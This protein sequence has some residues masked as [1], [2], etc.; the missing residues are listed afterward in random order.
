ML[1]RLLLV[2]VVSIFSSSVLIAKQVQE[3]RESTI[4]Y[5]LKV[6]ATAAQLKKFNNLVNKN[7]VLTKK[8]LKGSKTNVV[9]FK[10]I[11][12]LEK[13]FSKQ[14][15]DTG[16]VKFAEPDVSIPPHTVPNDPHYGVQWHH[17]TINSPLAWDNTQGSD[18]VKICVLDTGVDTDHPDLVG[19]LILP[20]YNAYLKVDGNV[21]DIYGHGTGTAG[22]VGAV[23][24]NA[25][26]VSGVNWNV[27][28][29]PVQINQGEISSSAYISDMAVGIEWCA[30]Q[31]AKVAN[32]SY[33]GAQYST[34]SESAQ[35]LRDSGGLLFMSAGNDG[36]NNS[37][38]TYPDYSSF[39]VVG[40]TGS[41]DIKSDFS[42]YGPFV[43]VVAP[44]ESIATTYLDGGYVY[45]SGTSFSSPM[46]AGLAG[47]IYSINPDFTPA[48]VEN[49][50]FDSSVDL[51]ELGDD[52]LYGKG[53]IDAGKAVVLAVNHLSP[54]N[55][56]VAIATS[57]KTVGEAPLNIVFDG[58]E[59][60]DSD[61]AITNYIWTFGDG[62]QASGVTT[63]HT[64]QNEGSFP[65]TLTVTDD[66]Y[67]ENI[68]DPIVI[69]VTPNP[70][71]IETPTNLAAVV[72]EDLNSVTLNWS[73]NLANLSIF[74]IY[75]AKKTRGKYIYDYDNPSGTS[76]VNSYI[77]EAVDA[78]DYRY[79]VR[80]VGINDGIYSEYSNEIAIKVETSLPTDPEPE[81]EPTPVTLETPVL[82]SSVSGST[83]TLNWSH[84]CP[85]EEECRYYLQRAD[86]AVDRK[87]FIEIYSGSEKS[88]EVTETAG[89]YYYRVYAKT[90]SEQSSD[91]N[92]ITFRIR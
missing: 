36:T 27:G 43:D 56:P 57:N 47:L 8:V 50:I 87:N 63:E 5:K 19:N 20:G 33:G 29:I 61:G 34:I 60:S 65:A 73:H 78:G 2:G 37:I 74:E 28:I 86:K 80:A 42:Q 6:D 81:P 31:G 92:I 72:D 83:I 35:Y 88:F 55:P 38:D 70:N 40:S 26:G 71:I 89:T 16:A 18:L 54:N 77:N 17:T 59:S 62:N 46:T 53:R 91:S 76:E 64:Y 90:T 45:Y 32:L 24:N 22:V 66:R 69:E 12:G 1:R 79:K 68:S 85:A 13:Q 58:S 48:Q 67:A 52:D 84:I 75:R 14:L 21:E 41:D 7:S 23:G 10:N 49:Y 25:E 9:K 39:V 15:M 3:I 51:G 11:K 82:S 4:L 30:D 44:G